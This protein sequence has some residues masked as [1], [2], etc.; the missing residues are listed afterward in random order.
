MKAASRF[1]ASIG[2]VFLSAGT[3]AAAEPSPQAT[4]ELWVMDSLARPIEGAVVLVNDRQQ[5]GA[6]NA[7]GRLSVSASPGDSLLLIVRAV[8]YQST[9]VRRSPGWSSAEAIRVVLTRAALDLPEIVVTGHNEMPARYLGIRR[10]QGFYD[11][12][13]LGRGY[14]ITREMLDRALVPD[15]EGVLNQFPM[16]GVRSNLTFVRCSGRGEKVNAYI[17]GSRM[18]TKDPREA[19]AT[20]H[21]NDIEAIEVYRN[22]AEIPPEFLD[23]NCAAIVIWT[24]VN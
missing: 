24:R 14:F 18:P 2:I 6:T 5:M 13:A 10:M 9:Y 23:D 12:R 3:L 15:V 4:V 7:S 11:R 21:P 20:I 16:R 19:L 1:G 22:T 17:N 8:G